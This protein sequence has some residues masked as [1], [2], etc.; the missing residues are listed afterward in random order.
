VRRAGGQVTIL[1]LHHGGRLRCIA[2]NGRIHGALSAVITR[3]L[4]AGR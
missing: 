2:T 4:R 3:A 1:D